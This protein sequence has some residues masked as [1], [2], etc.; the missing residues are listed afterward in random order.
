MAGRLGKLLHLIQQRILACP[1]GAHRSR[2]A[3]TGLDGFRRL[4]ELGIF[5]RLECVG[6][7]FTTVIVRPGSGPQEV[8][9][10]WRIGSIRRIR[11][12]RSQ[13]REPHPRDR[14][15][16]DPERPGERLGRRQQ[17]L[18]ESGHEQSGR[19]A[20]PL[21]GVTE[22]LVP[23]PTVVIEKPRQH[24]FGGIRGKTPD[25]NP[26]D[27]AFGEP[28]LDRPQVLLEAA[29]H[30]VP[31]CLGPCLDAPRE[32]VGIKELEQG[33]EAARV[34]IVRGCR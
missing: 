10:L 13:L 33:G 12:G 9:A 4:V 6:T 11:H 32:P 22:A 7:E 20:R 5:L 30:H 2:R 28:A 31:E 16:V 3:R 25:R 27:L 21:G 19:G 1:Q 26:D 29:D 18:L 15:P 17:A 8:T 23:D 34:P 14:L 24:E